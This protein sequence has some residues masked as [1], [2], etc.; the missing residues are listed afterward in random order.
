MYGSSLTVTCE[1][2]YQ[3][4]I[5][6]VIPSGWDPERGWPVLVEFAVA[7]MNP[8]TAVKPEC[9]QVRLLEGAVVRYLTPKM[10][11]RH[12]AS[13]RRCVEALSC[14]GAS[15]SPRNIVSSPRLAHNGVQPVQCR[16]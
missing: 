7:P 13:I 14:M 15:L 9:V 8:H 1:E 10:T 2:H 11:E 16:P 4:A 6:A 12:I 5:G 3:A